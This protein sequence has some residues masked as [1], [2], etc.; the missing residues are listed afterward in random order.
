MPGRSTPSIATALGPP[1][2][3]LR[4]LDPGPADCDNAIVLECYSAHYAPGV[5]RFLMDVDKPARV[6]D[7]TI[8]QLRARER[9][10]ITLPTFALDR[11]VVSSVSNR[12]QLRA[13]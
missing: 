4:P 13:T 9:N 11:C 8:H 10:V 1:H 6:P 7:A 3:T 2:L 12:T 5:V